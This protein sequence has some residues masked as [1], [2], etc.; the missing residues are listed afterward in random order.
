MKCILMLVVVLMYLDLKSVGNEDL[1]AC[2]YIAQ[3]Q[4]GRIAFQD[5]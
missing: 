1:V 2:E 4:D 3:W 5:M